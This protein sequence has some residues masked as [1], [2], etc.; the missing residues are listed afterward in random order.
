[1]HSHRELQ[2]VPRRA[3]SRACRLAHMTC[4]GLRRGGTRHARLGAAMICNC[5]CLAG[6]G[7]LRFIGSRAQE[8]WVVASASRSD[9]SAATSGRESGARRDPCVRGGRAIGWRLGSAMSP[10]FYTVRFSRHSPALLCPRRCPPRGSIFLSL[11]GLTTDDHV[12]APRQAL[13]ERAAA[14][15]GAASGSAPRP[16]WTINNGVFETA[17]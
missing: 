1:M 17:P 5:R 3:A 12:S 2:A 11:L 4:T 15:R 7:V 10:S 8:V 9:E 14:S 6:R 16:G 13:N